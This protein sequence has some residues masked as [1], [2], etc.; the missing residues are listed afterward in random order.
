MGA[1]QSEEKNESLQRHLLAGKMIFILILFYFIYV[2][3]QLEGARKSK[4]LYGFKVW[5]EMKLLNSWSRER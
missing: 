2:R 1:G 3:F 4:L 5:L